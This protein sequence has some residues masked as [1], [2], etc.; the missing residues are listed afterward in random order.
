[1]WEETFKTFVDSKP[2]GKAP[3][4]FS[5]LLMLVLMRAFSIM[6]LISLVC[7]WWWYWWDYLDLAYWRLIGCSRLTGPTAISLDFSL[8][9][10]EHVYGIPEHADSARLKTT[11]WVEEHTRWRCLFLR[12]TETDRVPVFFFFLFQERGSISAPQ[13]G[14]LQVRPVYPHGPLWVRPTPP[15]PQHQTDHRHLLAQCCWD[16][17]GY[18]LQRGW[19]GSFLSLLCWFLGLLCLLSKSPS[20]SLCR[21]C[22]SPDCVWENVRLC[23]GFQRGTTDR[24]ALDLWKWHHWCLHFAWT[25]TQRLLRPVRLPHR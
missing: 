1:M 24:C 2:N 9:G 19:K 25:N 6:C 3:I 7:K 21:L 14:C 20:V 23:A 22:L 5:A 8:P 13:H 17:G 15:G 18:Q 10:V 12:W 11:E 4:T 16:L